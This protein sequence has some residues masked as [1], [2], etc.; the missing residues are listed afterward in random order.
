VDAL[1]EDSLT[2]LMKDYFRGGR[3]PPGEWTFVSRVGSFDEP[4][5]L[6]AYNW[7]LDKYWRESVSAGEIR[8]A[9]TFG[10]RLG[11]ALIRLRDR[12]WENERQYLQGH[13]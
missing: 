13:H 6:Y 3:K 1:S 10:E 2:R 8:A 11:A 12:I 5:E 7:E 4:V 9:C